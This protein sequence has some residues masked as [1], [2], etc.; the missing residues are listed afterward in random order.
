[1]AIQR[2]A[3]TVGVLATSLL[4]LGGCSGLIDSLDPNAE[5]DEPETVGVSTI[6]V[7]ACIDEPD[8]TSTI[9]DVTRVPCAD[10]HD[11][12]VYHAFDLEG[13]SYPSDDVVDAAAADEC[14]ASFNTFVGIDYADSALD[15]TYMSPVV[16]GWAQGDREVLCMLYEPDG[17]LTGTM[18]GANR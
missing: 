5:P 7:G 10:P 12:E 18:Q 11:L 6:G 1:M 16:S 8:A 9:E 3:P 14:L 2:L 15:V 17:K 13:D 4:L